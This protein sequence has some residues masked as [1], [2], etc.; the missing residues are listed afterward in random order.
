MEWKQVDELFWTS[1]NGKSSIVIDNLLSNWTV[2]VDYNDWDNEYFFFHTKEQA[3][4]FVKRYI[5]FE[6]SGVIILDEL[7]SNSKL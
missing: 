1:E 7:N 3:I 2:T 4:D 5:A 6:L